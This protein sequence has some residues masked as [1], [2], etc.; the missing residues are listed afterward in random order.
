MIDEETLKKIKPGSRVKVYEKSG[1]FEGIV[2]ARKHG[3]EPGATFTVR[4]K[5]AD[6]GVEKVYP[7]YSPN[8]KKVEILTVPRRKV[9]RAKLYYLRSLSEKKIR[10]KLGV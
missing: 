8:I 4:A 7:I 5:L 9:R 3:T 6:V 1:M 10:H 2:L